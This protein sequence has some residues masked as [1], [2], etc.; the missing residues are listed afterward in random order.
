MYLHL[1]LKI[2]PYKTLLKMGA[3]SILEKYE[4]LR[5]KQNADEKEERDKIERSKTQATLYLPARGLI[6]DCILY[7]QYTEGIQ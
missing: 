1:K 6:Y 4:T 3:A 7:G 5:R 2:H